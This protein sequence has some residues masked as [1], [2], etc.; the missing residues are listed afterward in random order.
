MQRAKFNVEAYY[1]L[2]G[3]SDD[4]KRSFELL[5]VLLPQ[6]FSGAPLIFHGDLEL[7]NGNKHVAIKNNT[8]KFLMNI[9]AVQGELDFYN[10]LRQI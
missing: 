9:P 7:S 6:F 10:F 8:M 5:E 4:L 3:I 2:V 1:S